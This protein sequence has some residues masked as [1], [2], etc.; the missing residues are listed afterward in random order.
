MQVIDP[1]GDVIL[2]IPDSSGEGPPRKKQK[3][4]DSEISRCLDRFRVS[5]KHLILASDY[6]KA[7]L[8]SQWHEGK[9]LAST[10]LAEIPLDVPGC[11][12]TSLK[13]LMDIFHHRARQVPREIEFEVLLNIALAT[14]YLQC[15]EA[16][17]RYG[18]SW[19][20]KLTPRVTTKFSPNTKNW[21]FTAYVFGDNTIFGLCTM[22]AQQ[23]G[24]GPFDCGSLPLPAFVKG[25]FS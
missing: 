4:T 5:S 25:I 20:H 10:D 6:F 8:G 17:E 9:E 7:R 11:D 13:I 12:S 16:V 22:L 21:M 24:S 3:R 15:H 18:Y 1:D 23:G 2:V 19:L 14:D